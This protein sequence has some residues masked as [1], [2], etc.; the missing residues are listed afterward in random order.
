MSVHSFIYSFLEDTTRLLLLG[1]AFTIAGFYVTMRRAH[2]TIRQKEKLFQASSEGGVDAFFIFQA[3]YDG[4]GNIHALTLQYMNTVAAQM[5]GKEPLHYLGKTLA[6][7]LPHT[8]RHYPNYLYCLHSQQATEAEHYL[9]S[10]PLAGR[11]YHEQIVPLPD[12]IAITCRD[13]THRKRVER[14]KTEFVSIVSHELRTPLTSIHGSLGLVLGESTRLPSDIRELMTIAY[15][16]SERLVRLVNNILD[17]EKMESGN[18]DFKYHPIPV[19][20]LIEQALEANRQFGDK[21]GVLLQREEGEG[22]SSAADVMVMAD[23]DR[24]MQVL[25]NLLSNAIKF[26]TAGSVVSIGY[27]ILNERVQFC[28]IDHGTGIP[29]EFHGRIFQKFAQADSSDTRQKGGTGLGL[30]I[31]KNILH[32]MKGEIYF[33]NTEGGGTTFYFTLPIAQKQHYHEEKPLVP[34]T[35]QPV[36]AAIAGSPCHNYEGL[37]VLYA[38]DEPDIRAIGKRALQAIGKFQV[39]ECASAP[40]ALLAA[41]SFRP[42]LIILDVMMPYMNGP[43]AL[44]KFRALACTANTPVIFMTAKVQP[45]EIAEYIAL[46]AL[47]VIPKPFEPMTLAD[48]I[49]ELLHKQPA[50][51]NSSAENAI[52]A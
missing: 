39:R 30:S 32:E 25:T 42:D 26:S 52:H 18:M 47:G 31:V 44:T 20:S 35:P 37:R 34:V 33:E 1:A 5:L 3:E 36:K 11:Y 21:Y 9:S 4:K 29:E 15:N 43:E 27:R 22:Y 13:I 7:V 38:E 12:S 8:V 2:R 45:Q 17:I 16:N 49:I 10:G 46:G 40:E 50:T 14:M 19:L 51:H 28:V 41:T 6:E 48:S 23:T 24:L